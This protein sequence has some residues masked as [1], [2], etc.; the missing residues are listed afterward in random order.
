MATIT[1]VKKNQRA[2]IWRIEDTTNPPPDLVM[3]IN[4]DNLNLSYNQLLNE[5]RTLGGFVEEFWGE[6]LT[7]FS[8]SG[9]TAMFYSSGGLTRLDSKTSTAY[10]NFIYFLNIYR[11][12][13]KSYDNKSTSATYKNS[14]KITSVGTVVMNY[15]NKDYE[16][17]FDSFTIRELAEKPFYLEYDL[18]FK[19]T[20]IIGDFIVQSQNFVQDQING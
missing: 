10:E 8:A 17:F 15:I 16:G 2:I 4:P 11:N 5:T 12:N 9:R 20:R 1:G 7:T 13:G 18:S 14:N 3:L 19:V 6:Q